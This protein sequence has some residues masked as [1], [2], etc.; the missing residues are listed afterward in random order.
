M[1]FFICVQL[2]CGLFACFVAKAKNRSATLWLLLGAILPILGVVIILIL[3]PKDAPLSEEKDSSEQKPKRRPKR[4][5]G[6]YLPDCHGCPYFSRPLFD[7]SYNEN[8]KGRCEFFGRDLYEEPEER[9]S[10]VRI[11]K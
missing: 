3:S 9:K 1:Y 10:S 7:N 8:K 11:E 4:C 5:C 6:S 2:L